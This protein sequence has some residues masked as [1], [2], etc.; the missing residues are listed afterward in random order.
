M[1]RLGIGLYGIDTSSQAV[2]PLKKAHALSTKVLQI[3]KLKKGDTTGYSRS[4]VAT[5]DMTIAIIGLGYADGLMRAAGNG[6]VKVYINGESCSTCLLYTS[7]S[8]RD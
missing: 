8:P 3:K 5:E 7:P 1:V 2:S 6:S 4:G